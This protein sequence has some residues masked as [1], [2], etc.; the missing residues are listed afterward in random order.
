MET[1]WTCSSCITEAHQGR[2]K[3][4]WF[5]ANEERVPR[6]REHLVATALSH[7][8]P[9]RAVTIGLIMGA[10]NSAIIPVVAFLRTGDIGTTSFALLGQAYALPVMFGVFSQALAYRRTA[11]L[12]A[13]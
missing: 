9:A 6:I 7:G 10:I 5:D 1:L 2:M 12:I 8:I 11:K 4:Y 3:V 13:E